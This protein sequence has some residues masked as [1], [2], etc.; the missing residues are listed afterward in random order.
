MFNNSVPRG[1][2]SH[3]VEQGGVPRAV[4]PFII[5][6]RV[7]KMYHCSKLNFPGRVCDDEKA[8]TFWIRSTII[9]KSKGRSV[10]SSYYE[11][12]SAPA[13][14]PISFDAPNTTTGL[15]PPGVA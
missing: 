3:D 2:G 14:W 13:P 11:V 4:D 8:A 1:A 12:H 10:M 7:A 9:Q 5:I 6:D 15:G